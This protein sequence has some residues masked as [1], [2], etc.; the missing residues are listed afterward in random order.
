MQNLVVIQFPFLLVCMKGL[1]FGAAPKDCLQDTQDSLV[2]GFH[3]LIQLS[4]ESHSLHLRLGPQLGSKSFGLAMVLVSRVGSICTSRARPG[5]DR[6]RKD[7]GA[8]DR[9]CRLGV[10]AGAVRAAA[11]GVSLSESR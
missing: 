7:E 3:I 1:R 5:R 10:P 2:R 9:A 6:S 11:N 4:A 8:S